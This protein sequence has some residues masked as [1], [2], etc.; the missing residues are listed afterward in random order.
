M[1]P[2]NRLF[3]PILAGLLV[4]AAAGSAL[5]QE[6]LTVTDVDGDEVAIEDASRTA[7]LGGVCS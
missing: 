7:T 5:A 2:R 1:N 4:C 6:P 3:A